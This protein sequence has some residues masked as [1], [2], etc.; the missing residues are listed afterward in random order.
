MFDEGLSI[1]CHPNRADSFTSQRRIQIW[2]F[3]AAL[4]LFWPP[5]AQCQEREL[6]TALLDFL[7]ITPQE[8][9]TAKGKALVAE[10]EAP[11]RAR[12]AVYGG[13]VRLKPGALPPFF[14]QGPA[15]V[16]T[17]MK[18]GQFAYFSDPAQAQ[19]L[20]SLELDKDDY[21]VLGECRPRKCR[22][23]L[24]AEGI[25]EAQSLDW[26]KPESREEFLAWFRVSLANEMRNFQARG[27]P[28]LI[29]YDDK[30]EPYPAASGI[31]RLSEEASPLLDLYP[32]LAALLSQAPNS[33]PTAPTTMN[34][35]LWSVSD[36]GYRPTLSV[37]RL[38]Y[39]T[40]QPP[41]RQGSV[42]ALQ[43]L[44]S[45]HYLAGR[46]QT[47]GFLPDGSLPGVSGA[48]FWTL[49]QI[50]FD[51]SLSTIKRSLL[52]RGLR[53]EVEQRLKAIQQISQP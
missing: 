6:G 41:G 34:T 13:L 9:Q 52:G 23:K 43:N 30:P 44:Y 5:S 27:F 7:E 14:R 33:G 17:L 25:S 18:P 2:A 51:D 42:M 19:D 12:Q 29:T 11:E 36:F 22:F 8:V 47:A 20:A 40:E 39:L 10:I 45:N 16:P 50:L 4:L 37:D 35:V 1:S 26:S 53:S 3:L 15:A 31:D 21:E 32:Q 48:F 24:G 28:A 38:A 46:L 49:D